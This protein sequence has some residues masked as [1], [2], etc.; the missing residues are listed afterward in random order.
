M[1]YMIKKKDEDKIMNVLITRTKNQDEL[2]HYGVPGMKWGHRKARYYEVVGNRP[3]IGRMNN[4]Q[5]N[6]S[7]R[8]SKS[9]A[10]N[11]SKTHKTELTPEQK[12]ARRKKA[13]KIGAAVAGTALAAYGTYK[14]AKFAQ[15]KRHQAALNKA[16]EYVDKNFLHKVGESNFANGKTISNFA[17][18]TG[19]VSMDIGGR[20]STII[21]QHNAKVVSTGRQIYKDATNTRLDKGLSKIV[22][23]GD[24]VGNAVGNAAK[25][26]GA[27]VARA[28][29]TVKNRALDVVNPIYT[30]EPGRTSVNTYNIDGVDWTEKRTDYYKRKVRR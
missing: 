21:G 3:R 6:T 16:S 8:M 4:S 25:R 1:E 10:S 26:T 5:T 22:G 11:N 7:A 28:G 23:A 27:A 14:L 20:G 13:L 9:S 18:K 30:Y 15:D 24:A 2:C 19:T 17:N 29:T 12:S